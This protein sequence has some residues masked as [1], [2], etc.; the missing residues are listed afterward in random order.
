MRRVQAV[1]EERQRDRAAARNTRDEIND[2]G[3]RERIPRLGDDRWPKIGRRETRRRGSK[4]IDQSS[5]P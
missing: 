4:R 2:E 5:S 1:D 3:R